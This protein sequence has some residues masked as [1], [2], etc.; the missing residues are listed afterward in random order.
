MPRQLYYFNRAH[1]RPSQKAFRQTIDI[2]RTTYS[3]HNTI[4]SITTFHKK[5]CIV[6]YGL[7]NREIIGPFF[8]NNAAA[9]VRVTGDRYRI[10][11]NNL[12]FENKNAVE[13]VEMWFQ[14]DG[15]TCHTASIDLLK[16][17]FGDKLISRNEPVNWPPR[18]CDLTPFDYFLY[19]YV[20]SLV[21]P[22]KLA[23]INA[24]KVNIVHVICDIW[25]VVL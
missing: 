5:K 17:K 7:H 6:W 22:D 2:F 19:G 13:L 14:Q 16:S 11:V 12:L 1:N 20:K 15:A 9:C 18:S 23:T 24:L 10:R 21:Y 4:I 3:L 25:S 8:L